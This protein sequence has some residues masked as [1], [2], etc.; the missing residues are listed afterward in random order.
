MDAGGGERHSVEMA[1]R[2][3]VAGPAQNQTEEPDRAGP[4][5]AENGAKVANDSNAAIC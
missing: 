4:T 3:R 1:S 5:L 2:D